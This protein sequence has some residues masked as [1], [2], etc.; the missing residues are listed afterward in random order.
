MLLSRRSTL[1]LALLPGFALVGWL[2]ANAANAA[3][4][5]QNPYAGQV[6]QLRATAHLL[7]LADHDYQGHRARAVHDIH[8]AI[9]ILHPGQHKHHPPSAKIVGNNEPQSVSDAQLR[10]AI[11]QLQAIRGQLPPQA[12]V[13]VGSAIHELEIALTIR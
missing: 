7:Q 1:A 8:L 4:I 11:T 5:V 6:A 2:S 10:Q 12:Q 3:A 13:A 9:H